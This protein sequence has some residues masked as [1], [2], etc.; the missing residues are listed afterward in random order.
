MAKTIKIVPS[1]LKP[2]EEVFSSIREKA[3]TD[4]KR[5]HIFSYD[6]KWT[7]KKDG[8]SRAIRVLPSKTQALQIAKKLV[9]SG[10][11][12]SIISHRKDGTFTRIKTA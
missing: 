2:S 10:D 12:E 8:A 5:V 4:G 7:V 9:R 6:G 3:S 11:V 1:N